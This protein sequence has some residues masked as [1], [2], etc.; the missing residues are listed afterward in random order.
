MKKCL[1]DIELALALRNVA[2]AMN[3]K[4]PEGRLGLSCPDCRQPVKPFEDGMQGPHFEHLKR[5]KNCSLSDT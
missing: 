5:N 4:I 2:Q 3:L 1:I